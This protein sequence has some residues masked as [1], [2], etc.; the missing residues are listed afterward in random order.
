MG[1]AG[2]TL[3]V[4]LDPF[5]IGFLAN[6]I[7]IVVATALPK[8]T[9]SEERQRQALFVIPDS[10]KDPVEVQKTKRT[11][12]ASVSL[13]AIIAVVLFVFWVVPYTGTL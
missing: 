9:E 11:V 3:P 12:L 4:Y 1:V 7:G 13:G 2:I 8:K 6:I 5:F 10:E